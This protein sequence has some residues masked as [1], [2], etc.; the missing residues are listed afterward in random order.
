[1][2][3]YIPDLQ[4]KHWYISIEGID[5]HRND[6]LMFEVKACHNAYIALS[7]EPIE[8]FNGFPKTNIS[9]MYEIFLGEDNNTRSG[10]RWESTLS[11]CAICKSTRRTV[12]HVCV[13]FQFLKDAWL[14]FFSLPELVTSDVPTKQ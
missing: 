12:S 13:S 6:V 2:D 1:M 4:E 5:L 14:S 9:G 11:C 3:R 10:I 7:T 8:Q